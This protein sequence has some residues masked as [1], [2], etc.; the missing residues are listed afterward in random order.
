M[1]LPM[2]QTNLPR[3]VDLPLE[4]VALGA[5]LILVL[6]SL[7]VVM[8]LRSRRRLGD[9]VRGIV[10]SLE[11]LRSG[12]QT[13]RPEVEAG[14]ALE[15]VS[16][17]VD[18]LGRELEASWAEAETTAER[19]R[20]L[21]DAAKDTAVITTDTDGDIR[22]FSPG[23]SALFGWEEEDVVSRPASVV[24][25][26]SSYKDLLPKLARRSLRAQGITTRAT[27]L[28]QDESGFAAEVSVRQLQGSAAQPIGFMM[29]VR[30]ISEQNRLEQELRE[31]E[32]RF[33]GLVEDLA[34][35]VVIVKEGRV[36]YVNPAAAA[37]C[38]STVQELEGTLWRERVATRDLLV[39]E[40]ALAALESGARRAD[41]LRCTLLGSD[42]RTETEL[43][44]KASAVDFSGEAAVLLVMQDRTAELLIES[45]MR[46]N[47]ARLDAVLEATTDGVLVVSEE[48]DGRVVIA[49]KAFADLLGL[50][51]EQLLGTRESRL[52]ALL[53]TRGGGAE[54]VA[55]QIAAEGGGSRT[56]TL[57]LGGSWPGELQV[58]AVGLRGRRAERLG[59]VVTLHDLTEQRQSERKLQ[60]QAEKLQL[61]KVELEQAYRRLEEAREKLQLRNEDLDRLNR[62]LRRLDEMKSNLLGNVSHELQTP[63]VSIRGYTE[64]ILKERLGPITGEQRKGL[65]LALTNIDRLISMIDNLLTFARADPKTGRLKLTRF[66]LKPLIQESIDL[67]REKIT[68]KEIDVAVALDEPELQLQADRDK[69]LQVFLNLLSNAIKFNHP[70]GRIEIT[71]QPGQPG[72]ATVGVRDSGVGIP[73]DTLGRIFDRHFKAGG[74]AG[75]QAEGSGIGLAIVRDILR[76]HGCTIQVASRA[77][78]GAE[79]TFTL[80]LVKEPAAEE[81]TGRRVEVAEGEPQPPADE[82]GGEAR[83][84]KPR[85][86][87]LRIIRPEKSEGS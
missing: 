36:F 51:I 9:D 52:R 11:Q 44:I 19:W 42:G 33:R 54:T 67:F 18:R 22:S 14:S 50:P 86:P 7:L 78:Q 61:G 1:Q 62:E 28:R 70:R 72:F 13:R 23:A 29:V 60:E 56:V 81:E 47:E 32:Q 27:L 79:F 75:E 53:C 30:D 20:A 4:G 40:E 17:A 8:L 66:K 39:V 87:R 38:G 74:A 71:A 64:M 46:H 77:G 82:S 57:A 58:T 6:A 15:V 43:R 5:L 65:D 12:R 73:E 45:E 24:F 25:D 84:G 76:L 21:T 26:E 69:I 59:K 48:P 83:E 16:D 10:Q 37:L 63:L 31:S 41:E 55:E 3:T 49:N 68:A 35:G 85:R 34:E 2:L 80:P